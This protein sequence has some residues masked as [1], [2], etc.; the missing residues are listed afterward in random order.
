MATNEYKRRFAMIYPPRPKKNVILLWE[1][2]EFKAFRSK[3]TIIVS[4]KMS[5]LLIDLKGILCLKDKSCD[6]Q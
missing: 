3:A 6:D 1:M 5:N 4:S 2:L